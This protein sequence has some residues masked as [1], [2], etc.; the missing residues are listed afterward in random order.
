MQMVVAGSLT[1]A[2]L[3]QQPVCSHLGGFHLFPQALM[4]L[5]VMISSSQRRKWKLRQISDFPRVAKQIQLEMNL[6]LV[7]IFPHQ[8]SRV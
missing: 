4:E 6:K 1:T 3:N 8:L 7:S 5:S 2:S